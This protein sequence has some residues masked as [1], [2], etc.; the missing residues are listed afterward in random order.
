MV[1]LLVAA[2]YATTRAI[3]KA[4]PKWLM[5]AGI[6]IGMGFLTKMLQA[7]VVIPVFAL[8]YLVAASAPLLKRIA[9]VLLAGLAVFVASSWWVII[10]TTNM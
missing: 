7:Y 10:G 4:N 1:L 5:L 3:E 8:A 2:A 9:H 6:L